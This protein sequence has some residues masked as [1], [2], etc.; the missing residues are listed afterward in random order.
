MLTLGP[1]EA[2]PEATS[3]A[4]ADLSLFVTGK[5]TH[6]ETPSEETPET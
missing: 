4:I 6:P 1:G 5:I 3:R 2:D